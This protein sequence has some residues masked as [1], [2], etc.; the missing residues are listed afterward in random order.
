[1]KSQNVDLRLEM[2]PN[3]TDQ[4]LVGVFYKY[5]TDPIEYTVTK[6]GNR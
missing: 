6:Y 5:I 1:M 4:L 3:V 2:F